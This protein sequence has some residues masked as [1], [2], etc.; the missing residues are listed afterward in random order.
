[1][2]ATTTPIIKTNVIHGE[3]TTRFSQAV[4]TRNPAVAATSESVH[5]RRCATHAYRRQK[6]ACEAVPAM[7]P[8]AAVEANLC[9]GLR[10]KKKATGAD[11]NG[12][13][14]SQPPISGP[15]LRPARL[16]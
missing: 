16:A 9:P 11:V 10:A 13:P 8:S 7:M 3:S 5:P 12:T 1:M 4:T 6:A 14:S 2:E 15:H